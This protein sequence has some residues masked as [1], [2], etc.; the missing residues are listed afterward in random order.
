MTNFG[1]ETQSF[2]KSGKMSIVETTIKL[3]YKECNGCKDQ[4]LTTDF[5]TYYTELCKGCVREMEDT[6]DECCKVDS[7]RVLQRTNRI[8]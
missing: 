5:D 8:W 6:S 2:G 3:E 4:V 7:L 1:S